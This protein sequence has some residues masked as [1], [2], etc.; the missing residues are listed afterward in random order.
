[1]STDG[2]MLLDNNPSESAVGSPADT[3]ELSTEGKKSRM[4]TCFTGSIFR[5][6]SNPI[7][8]SNQTNPFIQFAYL[9]L[10]LRTLSIVHKHN[11]GIL[12]VIRSKV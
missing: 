11:I 5:H 7:S 10:C 8:I 9:L 12:I 4:P 6:N 2:Q 3:E 1:M